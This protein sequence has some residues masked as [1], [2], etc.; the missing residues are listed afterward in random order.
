MPTLKLLTED[1]LKLPKKNNVENLKRFKL[2]FN[3][4]L[5]QNFLYLFSIRFTQIADDGMHSLGHSINQNL[6]IKEVFHLD[7]NQ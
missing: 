2:S 3:E 1:I 5:N 4:F 6:K 7:F